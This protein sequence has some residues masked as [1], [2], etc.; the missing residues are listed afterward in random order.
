M[1]H[2]F[3]QPPQGKQTSKPRKKTV[4]AAPGGRSVE[5]TV[6]IADLV[7]KAKEDHTDIIELLQEH[8]H[9]VEEAV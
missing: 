7:A 2:G 3:I 6:C 9:V 4:V 5:G 8:I 1:Q